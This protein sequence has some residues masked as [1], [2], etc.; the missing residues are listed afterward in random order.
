MS[1]V[2]CLTA[3]FIWF[4]VSDHCVHAF[5]TLSYVSNADSLGGQIYASMQAGK[6]MNGR[7]ALL[8]AYIIVQ[9]CA[10]I[11]TGH[12]TCR[13]SWR[14]HWCTFSFKCLLPVRM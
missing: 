14:L 9:A 3:L 4:L 8:N 6:A 1:G 11:Y 12:K 2:H 5:N 7:N 10:N 13:S